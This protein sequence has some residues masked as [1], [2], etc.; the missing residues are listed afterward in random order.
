[1]SP[2][3][4]WIAFS[5]ALV[6]GTA[7]D[8][9][10]KA[11]AFQALPDPMDTR[12]VIEGW[13]SFTHATNRGAAFGLFQGQHTFFMVV[14]LLAFVAV[15]YFVHTSPRNR[16][17][18]ITAGVLGLILAGVM[19]NFWDRVVHGFVRDF[20]DVHTPP[21][22]TVHDLCERLFGR[23]VWPTFNVADIFITVGAISMVL[24]LG[25]EEEKKPAS[26]AAQPAPSQDAAPAPAAAGAD[27]PGS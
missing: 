9:A 11:W 24:F 18:L 23:T 22:G 26:E 8:L 7:L 25:R 3:L 17:G 2:A 20:L 4:R 15:P 16:R 1:M 27:G 21:A 13:F 5:L 12:V 6:L 10:T 19:G 14:S